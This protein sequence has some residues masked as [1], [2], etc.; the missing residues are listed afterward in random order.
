MNHRLEWPGIEFCPVNKISWTLRMSPVSP[1]RCRVARHHF[2]IRH[3]S[4]VILAVSPARCRV[5]RSGPP[6]NENRLRP[7]RLLSVRR[8]GARLLSYRLPL[9]GTGTRGNVLY[10]HLAGR[11]TIRHEG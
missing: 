5:A 11:T 7:V 9:R 8:A 2:V 4:F 10:P 1:T 6:P 3:S